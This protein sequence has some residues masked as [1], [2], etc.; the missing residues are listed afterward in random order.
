MA[1]GHIWSIEDNSID[2]CEIYDVF[3]RNCI[4][5]NYDNACPSCN[6]TITNMPEYLSTECIE[7]EMLIRCQEV[8]KR[9]ITAAWAT[10]D[11]LLED[12]L[13]RTNPLP[14]ELVAPL[15]LAVGF[16]DLH[17]VQRLL[18]YLY[19]FNSSC[20]HDESLTIFNTIEHVIAAAT[21][22]GNPMASAILDSVFNS[23]FPFT[24]SKKNETLRLGKLLALCMLNRHQR[25]IEIICSHPSL[26]KEPSPTFGT[27]V[28]YDDL[29]LLAVEKRCPTVIAKAFEEGVTFHPKTIKEAIKDA[30]QSPDDALLIIRNTPHLPAAFKDE[31][32]HSPWILNTPAVLK[33]LEELPETESVLN[34]D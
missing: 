2:T 28:L 10:D 14:F 11:S 19:F 9:L 4:V 6:R 33:A 26:F 22:T 18:E 32:L 8:Q 29:L 12:L 7:R 16:K 31:L 3:H 1:H 27:R 34:L 25:G 30:K 13:K 20:Q 5:H 21:A 23:D 17:K 24:V 15:N